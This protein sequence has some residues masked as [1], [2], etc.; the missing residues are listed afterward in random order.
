MHNLQKLYEMIGPYPYDPEAISALTGETVAT[1][2]ACY[3]IG[4]GFLELDRGPHFV[5]WR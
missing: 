3:R 5:G 2:E 4:L 1:I